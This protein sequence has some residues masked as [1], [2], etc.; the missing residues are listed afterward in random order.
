M[1]EGVGSFCEDLEVDPS[2]IVMLVISWHMQARIMCEYSKDEFIG[3]LVD[4]G[5]DSVEK[6][7][8]RLSS[9][10]A[11]L[12]EEGKFKEIYNY[13]FQFAREEGQKSL[14]LD[15]AVAMWKLLF[16]E[17]QWPLV[18]SWCE[19]LQA[20]HNKSISKDTWQQLLDFS[21]VRF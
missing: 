21:K 1:A 10:R 3:G 15:T 17:R 16:A 4:L 12:T 5:C 19:F 8:Q 6:L 7:K 2:D 13:A 14:A 20:E 18:D 11:E 9:L